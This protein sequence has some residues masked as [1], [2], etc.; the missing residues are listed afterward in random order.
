MTRRGASRLC[1]PHH[2]HITTSASGATFVLNLRSGRCYVINRLAGALWQELW[3]T[4]DSDQ[5]VDTVADQYPQLARA[6][7]RTR[8]RLIFTELANHGLIALRRGAA[9]TGRL[10]LTVLGKPI[11]SISTEEAN[12]SR[13]ILL[14]A[15]VGLFAAF[16]LLR[17][18]FRLTVHIVGVLTGAWCARAASQPE[19][20]LTVAAVEAAAD[21]YPGRAA[22]LERSLGCVITASLTRQ[23]LRWVIGVAEDPCRF[24]AWV[25]T[26]D[27]AV[28]RS[29]ESHIDAFIRVLSI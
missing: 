25:E 5:A 22:C 20:A 12:P 3:R 15:H 10:P 6:A 26:G 1:I 17:L 8:A 4:G 24:H 14:L 9:A 18:P 2:V 16:C 27:V 13:R 28:T 19:A 11:G 21:R 23:R 7:F 29:P